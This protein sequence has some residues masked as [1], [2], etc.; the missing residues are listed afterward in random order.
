MGRHSLNQEHFSTSQI[1]VSQR[2]QAGSPAREEGF[3]CVLA[4]G[5][6]PGAGFLAHSQSAGMLLVPWGRE[7][8]RGRKEQRDEVEPQRFSQRLSV[9]EGFSCL[10]S[11]GCGGLPRAL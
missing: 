7:H 10:Q 9:R 5:P 11:W 8:R 6:A 2:L 4:K 1:V 3:V